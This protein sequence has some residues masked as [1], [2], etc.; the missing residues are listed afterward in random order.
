MGVG[1]RWSMLTLGLAAAER[2]REAYRG[3]PTPRSFP[4]FA[5]EVKTAKKRMGRSFA[6]P[7]AMQTE[8]R[9]RRPAGRD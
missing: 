3:G 7:L 4:F 9:S 6:N 8:T 5:R 2:A 1:D